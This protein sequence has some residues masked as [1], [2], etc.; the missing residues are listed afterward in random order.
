MWAIMVVLQLM[1]PRDSLN[2]I[3]SLLSLQ[4]TFTLCLTNS[5]VIFQYVYKGETVREGNIIKLSELMNTP[6]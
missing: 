2:N 3:V 5:T 6:T 4:G 1:L